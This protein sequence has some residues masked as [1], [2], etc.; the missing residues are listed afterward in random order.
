MAS[1]KTV[2]YWM[3]LLSANYPNH[4]VTKESI[5]IYARILSDIPDDLL[6]AAA[7]NIMASPGAF[8][9]TVGD[10]R[11]SALDLQ[12]NELGIPTAYEAWEEVLREVKRCGDYYRWRI[13]EGRKDPSWSSPL[14][15]KAVECVGYQAIQEADNISFLQNHFYKT[16]DALKSRREKQFR[17]LPEVRQAAEKYSLPEP[18]LPALP[19]MEG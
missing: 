14:V 6:E 3:G 13:E 4:T 15:E 5:M 17:M 2:A 9:P 12:W 10:W 8:F 11:Q 16:Y 1:D 18:G 19:M 7:V